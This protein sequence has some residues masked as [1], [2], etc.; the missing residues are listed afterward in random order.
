MGE[1]SKRRGGARLAPET[2]DKA[3]D[4]PDKPT[5]PEQKADAKRKLLRGWLNLLLRIALMALVGFLLFTQV[6]FLGRMSGNEMFPAVKDGDLL[7]GFRVGQ[8]FERS[9]VVIYEAADG[10]RHVGRVIA[11]AGDSV[12]IT[13]DGSVMV[14]GALQNEEVVNATV[15]G[16]GLEYPYTVPDGCLFVLGDW[17]ADAGSGDSRT[18]GGISTDHVKAQVVTLLRRR[19]I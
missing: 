9:S 16:D 4:K 11:S 8:S 2:A 12:T 3:Q 1:G 10:V 14:N 15:P 7:I 5:A 6:L 13:E 17:R 19:G 18:L